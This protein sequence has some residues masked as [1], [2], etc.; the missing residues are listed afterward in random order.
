[1]MSRQLIV[2]GLV[3]A[4]AGLSE[5]RFLSRRLP[6]YLGVDNQRPEEVEADQVAEPE[7]EHSRE[8]AQNNKLQSKHIQRGVEPFSWKFPEDPVRSES[9]PRLKFQ[10]R[11]PELTSNRVA[12]RC[13][14]SRIQVEVNQD[15][16]GFG[17][18]IKP[19]EITLGGCSATEV[20]TLSHVLIFEAELHDCGSTLVVRDFNL[21]SELHEIK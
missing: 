17:K 6:A 1:M 4:F 19:E 11:R 9:N 16:R 12:L 14:E 8:S 3:L 5:V 21:F 7:R 15:L 20:D 18:L 10:L 13:G 2:F